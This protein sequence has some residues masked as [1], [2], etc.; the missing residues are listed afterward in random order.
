MNKSHLGGV[1]W[2]RGE[3]KVGQKEF[4]NKEYPKVFFQSSIFPIDHVFFFSP[5]INTE[6]RTHNL[7]V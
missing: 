1:D 4:N 3:R 6:A 5:H 7:L 2:K